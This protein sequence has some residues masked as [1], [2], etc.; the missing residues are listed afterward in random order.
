MDMG[1]PTAIQLK[2]TLIKG[3]FV[4]FKIFKFLVAGA[5]CSFATANQISISWSQG[6]GDLLRNP[7][8][9]GGPIPVNSLYLL[10]WSPV[11]TPTD[12][13]QPT[14]NPFAPN[15]GEYLLD[16][17][18]NVDPGFFEFAGGTY[19]D[20]DY[21]ASGITN[22]GNGFV[23]TRAFDYQG[24]FSYNSTTSIYSFDFTGMDDIWYTTSSSTQIVGL[25]PAPSTS[26]N[27]FDGANVT[28][29]SL[30]VI[31]EPG[32]I[33]LLVFGGLTAMVAYRRRRSAR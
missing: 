6:S 27:P 11:S 13:S 28:L 18:R 4:K 30:Y 32:T 24:V 21:N 19:T 7:D 12:I 25:V 22:F 33:G 26:H 3:E 23:Y 10:Y 1:A 2:L 17:V 14:S 9:G 15:S 29:N 20:T 8:L 16:F 5:I 31:P